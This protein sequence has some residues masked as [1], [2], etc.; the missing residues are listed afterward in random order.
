MQGDWTW[1]WLG[2]IHR[3]GIS[4]QRMSMDGV[5]LQAQ[6]GLQSSLGQDEGGQKSTQAPKRHDLFL[7]TDHVVIALPANWEVECPR[8]QTESATVHAQH[9]PVSDRDRK[10]AIPNA[11][12]FYLCPNKR[13]RDLINSHKTRHGDAP[14]T[15]RWR[16]PAQPKYSAQGNIQGGNQLI[17]K[18]PQQPKHDLTWRKKYSLV[19][20]TS[21]LT[22]EATPAPTTASKSSRGWSSADNYPPGKVIQKSQ[23]DVNSASADKTGQPNL[24]E[25]ALLVD[26]DRK[27]SM[28]KLK[29]SA[30]MVDSGALSTSTQVVTGPVYVAHKAHNERAADS[31]KRNN[32]GYL[33]LKVSSAALDTRL[34]YSMDPGESTSSKSLAT[35][36]T[37]PDVRTETKSSPVIPHLGPSKRRLVTPHAI[38]SAP[39]LT[40][41]PQSP[42]SA[43]GGKTKYTWV[44]NPDKTSLNIKK[45]SPNPKRLGSV[46]TERAKSPSESV[47]AKGKKTSIHQ[48]PVT[49]K[50]K[51][52]WKA[53]GPAQTSSSGSLPVSSCQ[54]ANDQGSGPAYAGSPAGPPAGPKTPFRD[55][56]HSTY[57][58]KSRTKIIRRRSSSSSPT[59][60]KASPL[61]PL[62]MKSRYSLR[63]KQ[64]P[65]VKSPPAAKRNSPRGLVHITKHRLRRVPPSKPPGPAGRGHGS[66]TAKWPASS[67]VIKTRYR[68]VKKNVSAAC[69]LSPSLTWRARLLLLN[70]RRQLSLGGRFHPNQQRWQS[71]GLCF[72]GGAMYRVSANKLSKT[73]SPTM[74]SKQTPRAGRGDLVHTSPG[75]LNSSRSATP[76]RYIASRAV[77]RSL[78]IIRQAQH[79]KE[80]KEYCMYYNRFGKCNR[81]QSCPFIH[82]PEK[83]AVC[84]RFLR[85]TCKKTDGTCQFSH[86][87]S[88][89]KMP[90][91]SYFL[92]GICHNNDCP[93]SHV[94]VSRKAEICPDFLKGYCPMGEKCKL[95]HTLQCPDYARHGSCP[96]GTK[97]KL[98][99]RQ[100]KKRLDNMAQT[101]QKQTRPTKERTLGTLP[102]DVS[103]T[104]TS[105]GPCTSDEEPAG[106]SGL[107]KLPSFISLNCSLTPSSDV[108]PES[109]NIK[110]AEDTGTAAKTTG[111]QS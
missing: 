55:S 85:G 1:S 84:T 109:R 96:K 61:A 66:P 73:W 7:A 65:R 89:E 95:K 68:I 62:T 98:Q 16:N 45:T 28:L 48:K 106:R 12:K 39:K 5:M 23:T 108:T 111:H 40:S 38:F 14:A 43:R 79:K 11:G 93:Y 102:L 13:S 4:E 17:A 35:I 36:K 34:P 92:K 29:C 18:Q 74:S 57:K 72:I 50:S 90:V 88:K 30:V 9:S 76:S 25:N 105:E 83:V 94:Y 58:V 107:Q 32:P 22:K 99:H 20:Q 19:N 87:V 80:K 64:S 101:G 86:K 53:E 110:P 70:R 2:N 27:A 56:T 41:T 51:Y 69:C 71:R 77:Q 37:N 42:K 104:P 8:S 31:C 26:K 24:P 103:G 63:R 54:Y 21:N 47:L 44:A 59:E 60:K 75:A 33:G 46:D 91:C 78:A 10:I 67:R 49:P 100:R 52:S 15:S 3:R 97:C 6:P 82:D 81:G